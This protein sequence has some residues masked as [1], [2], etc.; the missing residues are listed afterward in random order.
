[1]NMLT[2]AQGMSEHMSAIYRE[3]HQYPELSHEETETAGRVVRWLHEIGIETQEGVGGCGVVGLL[4]GSEGNT[5]IALRSDMDALPI[6][7]QTG[8]PFRSSRPGRM[9]ACGHDSHMT[10]LLAAAQ[11]LHAQRESLR[12]NVKFIFQPAEEF[13]PPSP[14]ARLMIEDGVLENPRVDAILALHVWP[15]IPAGQMG[16]KAGPC[17]AAV[18]VFEFELTGPGGHGA[19]PHETADVVVA[20]AQ[21][22]MAFQTIISRRLSPIYPAALTVG[23]I[24]SGTKPNVI[25]TKVTGRGM[26]RYVQRDQTRLIRDSM[27]SILKGMAEAHGVQYSLNYETALPPTINDPQMTDQVLSA[28]TTVLG[29]ANVRSLQEPVMVSED[30]SLYLERIPGCMFFLG[31]GS[32]AT[33]DPGLHSAFFQVNENILPLGAAVL[34]QAALDFQMNSRSG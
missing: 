3:L 7:E 19:L 4:R 18:D 15:A 32:P 17:M 31:T 9:H 30:F 34:A 24:E 10:M 25:P 5:T 16:V 12:H 13:T 26:S 11:L 28:G 1:M 21:S 6:E 33:N 27:N 29:P 20:A 23:S 14:G 22:I 2:A 8:S